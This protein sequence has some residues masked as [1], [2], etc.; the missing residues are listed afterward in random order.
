V[1]D[2]Q[3]ND[4]AQYALKIVRNQALVHK[5]ASREVAILNQLNNQVRSHT[6]SL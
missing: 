3:R 6:V 1:I 5:H 4:G 2:H